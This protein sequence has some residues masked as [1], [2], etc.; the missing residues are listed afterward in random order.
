MDRKDFIKTCGLTC[1]CGSPLLVILKSCAPAR[2]INGRIITDE[3]IVDIK[4][5][6]PGEVNEKNPG[7]YIVVQNEILAYPVAVFRL[8]ENEY[9]ALWMECTHQGNEIRVY[10]DKLEC[11]AH[12]SVYNNKGEVQQGP[13]EHALKT[14]PIRVENNQVIISLKA[15]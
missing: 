13:A 1:L 7:N 10:G 5:F 9:S 15:K 11:P 8:S 14:F 6:N 2:I 12:G 3:L 4:D